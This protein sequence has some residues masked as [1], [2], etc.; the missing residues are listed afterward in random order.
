MSG[1]KTTPP[2]SPGLFNGVY[3]YREAARLLGVTSQRVARWADGYVFQ[4]KD[5]KGAS[6][7]VLQTERNPGVLSFP[8]LWELFFVKE[9]VALGV[10]LP[11]IRA[12]AENL[13]K[14]FGPLPFSKEKLLVG[15]RELLV[16]EANGVLKRPDI[17]QIVA[18]YGE[19][20]LQRVTIREGEV[21]RYSPPEFSGQLFL[22]KQIHGGEPVV[23]DYTIPTRI[24]FALWERENNIAA[25]ADY[26]DISRDVVSLAVRYEGAWRLAA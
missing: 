1:M 4:L 21:G 18:D 12:T 16:R 3:S 11:Q 17:G 24:I 23:G 15:G 13:A 20:M 5:G 9:Y 2:G 19:S 10:G 6:K 22:D 25:V 8:E 14:E 26:H 7:P